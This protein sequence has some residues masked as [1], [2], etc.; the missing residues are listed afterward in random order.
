M[1]HYFKYELNPGQ[2]GF[3]K[4]KSTIAHSIPSLDCIL[5]LFSSQSQVDSIYFGLSSAFGFVSRNFFTSQTLC[6]WVF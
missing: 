3:L 5:P 1:S 6:S 2:H 4:A